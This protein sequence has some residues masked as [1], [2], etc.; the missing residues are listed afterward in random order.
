MM[1]HWKNGIRCHFIRL[2]I[3]IIQEHAGRPYKTMILEE[4]RKEGIRAFIMDHVEENIPKEHSLIKLQ[5]HFGLTLEKAEQF[6]DMY[7][8]AVCMRK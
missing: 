7:A 2:K 8:A 4:G 5:K 1:Y 6:Y 3:P